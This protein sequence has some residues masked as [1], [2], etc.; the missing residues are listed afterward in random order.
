MDTD[1]IRTEILRVLNESGKIRGS[2]L[3][4][5]VIK[6]VGNEKMV[7]RE[8]S[9]LVESGEVERK[10]Y[11]KSHIEYQIINISESVNNQLKG[12]HKEIEVIFEDIREFKEI[13]EQN[14]I[15]FQER[16]RTTIHLIHIVQSIDGVMKLLSHYPTFK[17]DRMFSQI[18]RKI[19]DCWEGIM[20]VIV[21][22]PEEE[23]LNEVIANLRISQIG[24]ESVN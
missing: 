7:H 19:S 3:T 9:L 10:M 16:L 4:S 21:H 22:Q 2:E 14:K 13:I 5:R 12:V 23:F 8:I 18:T 6:R 1:I 17:K 24:S 20:D 11:S 15:E